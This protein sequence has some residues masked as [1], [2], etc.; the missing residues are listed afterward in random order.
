MANHASGPQGRLAACPGAPPRDP[1]P[2]DPL[3]DLLRHRAAAHDRGVQ[4]SRGPL[5]ALLTHRA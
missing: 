1:R 5:R 3:A 2:A 4:L